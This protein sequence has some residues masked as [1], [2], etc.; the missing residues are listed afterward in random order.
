[1]ASIVSHSLVVAGAALLGASAG[2]LLARHSSPGRLRRLLLS[3]LGSVVG[4]LITS[5]SSHI[6]VTFRFPSMLLDWLCQALGT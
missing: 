3:L 2:Y 5:V 6:M 4:G 1:M